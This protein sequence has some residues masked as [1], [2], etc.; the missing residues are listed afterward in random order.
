MIC[1]ITEK[2]SAGDREKILSYNGWKLIYRIFSSKCQASN[3]RYPLISTTLL[4]VHIEISTSSLTSTTPLNATMIRIDTIFYY[5]LNQ[6]AYG[7]SIQTIKQWKYC[8]YLDFFIIFGLL[9]VKIYVSFL[10]WKKKMSR[11]WRLILFN[12]LTLK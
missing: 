5:K 12:S 4:G 7:P 6:N 2:E 3:K 1:Y 11:F 9:I 8:W 10:F